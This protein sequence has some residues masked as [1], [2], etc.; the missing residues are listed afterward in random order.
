MYYV[1]RCVQ[2]ANKI[3]LINQSAYRQRARCPG[4]Y[5]TF[6]EAES[7]AWPNQS[8]KLTVVR[9]STGD[10]SSIYITVVRAREEVA[11]SKVLLAGGTVEWGCNRGPGAHR[12]SV[13]PSV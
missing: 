10:T 2:N 1:I 4:P 13:L 8:W 11:R 6:P 7:L 9:I 5:R 3:S 12:P